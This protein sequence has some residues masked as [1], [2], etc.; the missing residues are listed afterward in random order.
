[1]SKI[2]L[3]CG[4]VKK[5]VCYGATVELFYNHFRIQ[6]YQS[7][8]LRRDIF[9]TINTSLSKTYLLL[10]EEPSAI[11]KV[12][13]LLSSRILSHNRISTIAVSAFLGV[14]SLRYL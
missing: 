9:K 3:L 6:W 11:D 5:D 12:V 4:Q 8:S 14:H 2:L 13:L 7:D 10:C 1:M